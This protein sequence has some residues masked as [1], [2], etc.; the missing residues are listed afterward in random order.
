[1]S[2]SFFKR[3]FGNKEGGK[4]L[5]EYVD[6][7][8]LE[9]G[10]ETREAEI[11]VRIAEIRDIEDAS[12][13]KEQI[14]SGNIIMMD[15]SPILDNKTLKDRVVRDVRKAVEDVGGDIAGIGKG[16][17]IVTPGRIKI[18]RRIIGGGDFR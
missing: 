1:M 3:L 12:T 17:V 7:E 6:L 4:N 11:Y 16:E 14:Y 10:R 9:L 18:D 15:I 13:V 2:Q 8:E 5:E